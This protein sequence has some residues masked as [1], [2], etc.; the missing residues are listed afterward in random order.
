MS[1]IGR[2][3][4]TGWDFYDIYTSIDI[5]TQIFWREGQEPPLILPGSVITTGIFVGLSPNLVLILFAFSFP[6]RVQNFS[7]IEACILELERFL[8]LCK[9]K[10]KMAKKKNQR[11]GLLYF[12]NGWHD[13][14]QI[15]N[16]VSCYRQA[17]SPQIWCS[18]DK[19]SRIYE[20]MKNCY[21][22]VLVN[23][24]TPIY[25]PRASWATRHTT[26]CLNQ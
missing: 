1:Q 3:N 16:L 23:I 18:S 24:F 20:C 7:L 5:R 12:R 19:R 8:C 11:F 22:V 17:L 25:V 14:L 21:I 15:W 9:K 2:Q 13:F 10:K 6:T 4:I 26:V